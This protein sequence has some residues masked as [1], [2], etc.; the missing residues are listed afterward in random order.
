MKIGDVV[1]VFCDRCMR[2]TEH[3]YWIDIP[4]GLS[5]SYA[6]AT[7]RY[8]CA[9]CRTAIHYKDKFLNKEYRELVFVC[10]PAHSEAEFV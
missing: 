3:V 9:I 5:G 4:Y 8:E 2:N 10:E 1:S 7:E 6:S